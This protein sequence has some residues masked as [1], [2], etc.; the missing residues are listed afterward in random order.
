[1]QD[2]HAWKVEYP[3]RLPPC[4]LFRRASRKKSS[5]LSQRRLELNPKQPHP[6]YNPTH[7]RGVEAGTSE[8][9]Q[10]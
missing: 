6:M 10:N 4:N 9:V 2:H 3:N 7:P 1:M 5:A 8:H